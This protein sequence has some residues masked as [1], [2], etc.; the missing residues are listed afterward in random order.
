MREIMTIAC[1]SVFFFVMQGMMGMT[2][3]QLVIMLGS[4]ILG[5]LIV[6]QKENK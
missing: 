6:N 2:T 1:I 3:D 5:N 4:M